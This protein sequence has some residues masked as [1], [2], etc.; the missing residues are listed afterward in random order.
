MSTAA[1]LPDGPLVAWY[2]DD[3]TGSAAVMEVLSFAGYPS[4]LFFDVPTSE[5]RAK[6]ENY[7]G[8]GI[9]GVSRSKG[10]GWM[11]KYL[12]RLFS[13]LK[14]VGA[15]V[16]H[17]KVCSTLDSSPTVGSIGHAADLAISDGEWAPVV[18]G[19][20]EIGRYQ[21]FGNLFAKA[22]KDVFRLD[23]HPTMSVHPVTPMDEGDVVRH[24]EKQTPKKIGLVDLLDV[25]GGAASQKMAS[26]IAD[27]NQIVSFDV[28]DDETL[29]KVGE[30]IWNCSHDGLFAIGSQGLEYALVAAWEN[31]GLAPPAFHPKPMAG[32]DQVA[33][34]SGSCSPVTGAQINSAR[35]AGFAVIPLEALKVLKPND[36]DT[37][38]NRVVDLALKAV[39]AGRSPIVCAAQGPDDPSIAALHATVLQSNLLME[40]VNE[41]LGVGLGKILNRI[42]RLSKIT[43]AAIAGGDTSSHGAQQLGL[44]SVTAQHLLAPGAAVLTGHSDDPE[45]DG[46]EIALKGGQMGPPDYFIQ[47]RDGANS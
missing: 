30:A 17:Y 11:D 21:V 7:R 31:A 4:V 43:R 40:D 38:C 20:P 41:K 37:E 34:I 36:W 25:K 15:P 8:I 32:V 35:N 19:A 13:F 29:T 26:A 3:F 39:R 5:Q 45:I 27:G 2:G 44:Y 12:P 28:V 23:R 10:T 24:L 18:M 47:L 9:A 22:G 1:P 14:N 6:F 16:R 33:I 42:L 46:L